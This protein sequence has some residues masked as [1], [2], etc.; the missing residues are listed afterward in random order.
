MPGT[1]HRLLTSC[2][3]QTRRAIPAASPRPHP[4]P[5]TCSEAAHASLQ[6]TP[7]SGRFRCL[8]LRPLLATLLAALF[9]RPDPD[10][11][12]VACD[13][14]TFSGCP[15][16]SPSTSMRDAL[17]GLRTRN[18]PASSLPCSLSQRPPRPR[19]SHPAAPPHL[20]PAPRSRGPSPLTSYLASWPPP[21]PYRVH[22]SRCRMFNRKRSSSHRRTCLQGPMT[23]RP[24]QGHPR[25]PPASRALRG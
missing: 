11:L 17:R 6:G 13:P 21:S 10:I 22:G 20:P 25:A 15:R 8:C 24:P 9:L 23:L 3:P 18:P 19:T 7:V 14:W 12:S 4:C 1:D 16:L 5:R 2:S